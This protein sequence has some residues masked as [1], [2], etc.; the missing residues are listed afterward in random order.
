MAVIALLGMAAYTGLPIAALPQVD[1][2]TIQVSASLPGGSPDIMATSVATPLER[3][4]ALIPGLT[5]MTSS[6]S[7]G[8][9]SITL[10]FD[11]NRSIDA[12]AQDVQAAI[13]AAA[14]QL[15]KNLPSPPTYE[16]ANPADFLIMSL[17]VYSDRMPLSQADV[18]A[19]SY[20]AQQL[21][22]VPGVGVVDLHGEQKPAVRV[23]VD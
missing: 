18:Y 3:Q 4:L 13:N 2:P 7:L 21:S 9:A 16:K 20:I 10:Q 17:A 22:R 8:N 15:P 23:Q 12:A 11:L 19:D 5:E 6:S 1:L 14:S